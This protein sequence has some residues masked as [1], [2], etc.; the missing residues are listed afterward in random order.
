[1]FNSLIE[2]RS[3]WKRE[4]TAFTWRVTIPANST[5]RVCVPSAGSA[6]VL[7]GGKPLGD[8]SHLKVT[9]IQKGYVEMEVESGTYLFT[10]K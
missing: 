9:G 3:D 8:N 1:M 6:T 4:G 2:Q 10:V 7:E 5:A